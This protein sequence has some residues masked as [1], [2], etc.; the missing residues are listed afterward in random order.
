M[1]VRLEHEDPPELPQLLV[2]YGNTLA[3]KANSEEELTRATEFYRRALKCDRC[4]CG[5]FGN[6]R[7]NLVRDNPKYYEDVIASLQQL[8]Q[9]ILFVQQQAQKYSDSRQSQTAKRLQ[10]KL[11]ERS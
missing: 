6:P 5:P 4:L 1:S 10:A 7:E 9:K 11:S 3:K 8:H 2:N